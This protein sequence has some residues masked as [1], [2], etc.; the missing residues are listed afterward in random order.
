M[1]TYTDRTIEE[2]TV[3]SIDSGRI[4]TDDGW[5]H[6][7]EEEILPL[8]S[9]GMVVGHETYRNSQ[10]S[11]WMIDGQWV[12]RTSDEEFAEQREKMLAAF[13]EEKRERLETSREFWEKEEKALPGWIRSRIEHFRSVDAE[14][15]ELE[16]WGYELVIAKL[17]VAYA[18]MGSEIIG[19][20]LSEVSDS[21]AVT[22]IA[23]EVGSSGNQ[24]GMALALAQAHLEDPERDMA[25]TVAGLS[26]ITGKANYTKD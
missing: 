23:E 1:A 12:M 18:E 6:Y 7:A 20:R 26:P 4:T 21:D 5:S 25:G 13:A 19:K 17:A 16:G 8:F 9:P 11:G 14:T 22:K 10:T 24:H 3:K 2:V 15:F